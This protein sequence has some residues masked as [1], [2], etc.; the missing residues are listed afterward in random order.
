MRHVYMPERTRQW[1]DE[2]WGSN[3]DQM[4]SADVEMN[5]RMSIPLHVWFFG[6][7]FVFETWQSRVGQAGGIVEV[8]TLAH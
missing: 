2:V 5:S 1:C 4:V 6:L 8:T 7:E 3:L